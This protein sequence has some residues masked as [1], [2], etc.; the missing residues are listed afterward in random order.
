[1]EYTIIAPLGIMNGIG[2]FDTFHNQRK[3][4]SCEEALKANDVIVIDF[5]KDE[6]DIIYFQIY[7][8]KSSHA[9]T[10]LQLEVQHFPFGVDIIDDNRVCQTVFELF[11]NEK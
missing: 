5:V 9:K 7:H 10:Y 1:M 6:N 2:T 11:K 8:T 4:S 3:Y